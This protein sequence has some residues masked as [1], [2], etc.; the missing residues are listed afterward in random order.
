MQN[1]STFVI[2]RIILKLQ[3]YKIE[4]SFICML[5]N[6]NE[7]YYQSAERRMSI[8]EHI[9]PLPHG[10]RMIFFFFLSCTAKTT[11]IQLFIMPMHLPS[12]ITA[13]LG[14]SVF[15]LF[16]YLHQVFKNKILSY[17]YQHLQQMALI[18]EETEL[19]N[20]YINSFVCE[21]PICILAIPV[22]MSV[23]FQT[24]R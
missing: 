4:I 22:S 18:M 12:S 2:Y 17:S 20:K 15:C 6:C 14:N 23:K 7:S 16:T 3:K 1:E 10:H 13:A 19:L 11:Y 24:I 5:N 9:F 21:F 8:L